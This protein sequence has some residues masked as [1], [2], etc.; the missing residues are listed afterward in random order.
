[1]PRMQGAGNLVRGTQH[2]VWEGGGSGEALV[3]KRFCYGCSTA[4]QVKLQV[5]GMDCYVLT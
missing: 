2:R 4:R 3:Q 5:W 1:M